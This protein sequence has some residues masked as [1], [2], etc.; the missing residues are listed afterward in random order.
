MPGVNALVSAVIGIALGHVFYYVSI[1]RLG[2]TVSTG[3]IQLQ[4]FTVAAL[5]FYW[6]GEK[7][8]AGQWV[9]GSIAVVGAVLMLIAQQR[10]MKK[11]R[12]AKEI[13]RALEEETDP[14][15]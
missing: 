2:I 12:S 13:E 14:H 11:F 7:L 8:S 15:G 9:S 4:P 1:K 10:V 6:I 5:S 3:V